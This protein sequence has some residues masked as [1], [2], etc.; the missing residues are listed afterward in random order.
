MHTI[1]S[2]AVSDTQ[3][4]GELIFGIRSVPW[5]AVILGNFTV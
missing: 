2:F 4:I 1:S 3:Q 5:N